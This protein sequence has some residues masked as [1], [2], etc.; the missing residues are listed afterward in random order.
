MDHSAPRKSAMKSGGAA[1]GAGSRAAGSVLGGQSSVGSDSTY[2]RALNATRLAEVERAIFLSVYSM[3]SSNSL[4]DKIQALAFLIEPIQLLATNFAITA[5]TRPAL[6]FAGDSQAV[7]R[8]IGDAAVVLSNPFTGGSDWSTSLIDFWMCFALTCFT[9]VTFVYV[10]YRLTF[11][12]TSPE[13]ALLALRM[14]AMVEST[15]LFMPTVE[16]LMRF[17]LVQASSTGSL[18]AEFIAFPAREVELGLT[19]A[20]WLQLVIFIPICVLIATVAVDVQ[21][22]FGMSH[23]RAELRVLLIKLVLVIIVQLTPLEGVVLAA[24]LKLFL[25]LALLFFVV[26]LQ[27]Y[28]VMQANMFRTAGI[29]LFTW[30]SII[31]CAAALG[32]PSQYTADFFL[33]GAVPALSVGA[34][35]SKMRWQ[36]VVDKM[37]TTARLWEMVDAEE[38]FEATLSSCLTLDDPTDLDI[39]VRQVLKP[40]GATSGY[41]REKHERTLRRVLG[42]RG[43]FDQGGP[44]D[45]TDSG[46]RGGIGAGVDGIRRDEDIAEVNGRLVR[47]GDEERFFLVHWLYQRAVAE[48]GD[49]SRLWTSYFNF[50]HW[51][52]T[53]SRLR[54]TAASL[55]RINSLD[56]RF[57]VFRYLFEKRRSQVGQGQSTVRYLDLSKS[58]RAATVYHGKAYREIKAFWLSIMSR[59]GRPPMDKVRASLHRI[60][61]AERLASAA[62]SALITKHSYS[63]QVLRSYATFLRQVHN[64]PEEADRYIAMADMVEEEAAAEKAAALAHALGKQARRQAARRRRTPPGQRRRGRSDD[65]ADADDDDGYGRHG[66]DD[67]RWEDDAAESVE[68]AE[69]QDADAGA[70][71]RRPTLGLSTQPVPSGAGTPAVDPDADDEG[72]MGGRLDL[73]QP[74][75]GLAVLGGF[76]GGAG[77]NAGADADADAAGV[78]FGDPEAARSGLLE[79]VSSARDGAGDSGSG[80]GTASQSMDGIDELVGVDSVSS[81]SAAKPAGALDGT[82]TGEAMRSTGNPWAESAEASGLPARPAAA[83]EPR[84]VSLDL[85]HGV[86][87]EPGVREQ[88]AAEAMMAEHAIAALREEA[89][90]AEG[91]AGGGAGDDDDDEMVDPTDSAA[92]ARA[93]RAKAS[94]AIRVI[95]TVE[96]ESELANPRT[97]PGI[98]RFRNMLLSCVF[99]A[100]LMLT[101]PVATNMALLSDMRKST[102]VSSTANRREAMMWTMGSLLA[103]MEGGFYWDRAA[104]LSAPDSNA[105]ADVGLKEMTGELLHINHR[106]IFCDY[107][108]AE[109]SSYAHFVDHPV[110]E[111]PPGVA[112]SRS[113]TFGVQGKLYDV[114]SGSASLSDLRAGEE[115][116]VSITIVEIDKLA[117]DIAQQHAYNLQSAAE[118]DLELS[119][120][121][122]VALT[123]AATMAR[124]ARI[125][126]M[127]DPLRRNA[128]LK[129]EGEYQVA[130]TNELEY[131]LAFLYNVK[132][133]VAAMAAAADTLSDR[134]GV[135]GVQFFVVLLLIT[136]LAV[137]NFLIMP[138][139][140]LHGLADGYF[141]QHLGWFVLEAM[142]RSVLREALKLAEG[143]GADGITDASAIAVNSTFPKSGVSVGGRSGTSPAGGGFGAG[144]GD[145]KKAAL[146]GL[147]D[148]TMLPDPVVTRFGSY[149]YQ[150]RRHSAIGKALAK[151]ERS[152]CSG[153]VQVKGRRVPSLAEMGRRMRES[154]KAVA[155]ARMLARQESD[156]QSDDAAY[157]AGILPPSARQGMSIKAPVA[158]SSSVQ[159]NAG[160]GRSVAWFG[161]K[162]VPGSP[163]MVASSGES[164]PGRDGKAVVLPDSA[165]AAAARLRPGAASSRSGGGGGPSADGSTPG[166]SPAGSQHDL[167]ELTQADAEMAASSKAWNPPAVE[168][169]GHAK[170]APG[171]SAS[172]VQTPS[173]PASDGKTGLLAGTLRMPPLAVSTTNRGFGNANLGLGN[174]T[175]M[176]R[177]ASDAS[178]TTDDTRDANRR[179]AWGGST[180]GPDTA[181]EGAGLGGSGLADQAGCCRRRK[182]AKDPLQLL[183]DELKKAV[184]KEPAFLKAREGLLKSAGVVVVLVIALM[185]VLIVTYSRVE[186]L[187]RQFYAMGRYQALFARTGWEQSVRRAR[188]NSQFTWAKMINL[189]EN[190]TVFDEW[191]ISPLSSSGDG[192]VTSSTT[193]ITEVAAELEVYYRC[194]VYGCA[195]LPDP[196]GKPGDVI[197]ID[198]VATS[199]EISIWFFGERA[200]DRKFKEYQSA[201]R[202]DPD[203]LVPTYEASSYEAA[204]ELPRLYEKAF[205][206]W[207]SLYL[208]EVIAVVSVMVVVVLLIMM[209]YIRVFIYNTTIEV[210]EWRFVLSLLPPEELAKVPLA[211]SFITSSEWTTF[212]NHVDSE[213]LGIIDEDEAHI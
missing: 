57:A 177:L 112:V 138:W 19:I 188:S 209:R 150:V 208:I 22:L 25:S 205:E 53:A 146:A 147:T 157:A 195:D 121:L 108:E 6:D 149:G 23:G 16:V 40:P 104:Y 64:K 193:V 114:V 46:G 29:A 3:L 85:G 51:A 74:S 86:V 110:L 33:L 153:S 136:V 125:Y 172:P 9:L 171:E 73:T 78:G 166:H 60:G 134:T 128:A 124:Y 194:V 90:D 66:G 184:V 196:G 169:A 87:V 152:I 24:F 79:G 119:P 18:G 82:V 185:T 8:F 68:P 47:I 123:P 77:A 94:K 116:E 122:Y 32:A 143:E 130:L 20:S 170:V 160:P 106:L 154:R 10:G 70:I 7:S 199:P 63:T 163:V 83:Q 155:S 211:Q 144:G 148:P 206:D 37:P 48:Q 95:G 164:S 182:V 5:M 11:S 202:N 101:V 156:G 127:S 84:R 201:L 187:N 100:L 158:A 92:V 93:R 80:A 180:I 42:M 71:V 56:L 67:R 17:A 129:A 105:S 97:W 36:R 59:G 145:I 109:L 118:T 173:K 102:L 142:P 72:G 52:D 204:R 212:A 98:R 15:V 30:T 179:N 55:A 65:D 35:L 120:A 213:N 12:S 192:T 115:E 117:D 13:T 190:R 168:G 96:V 198:G 38:R 176:R 75:G 181:R 141:E 174:S 76:S 2:S 44:G 99:A 151:L 111:C 189:M 27:P 203:K 210:R 31:E 133:A 126:N 89:A 43:P 161:S 39:A 132:S 162:P 103:D 139:V 62:F 61:E 34:M 26:Q 41:L 69:E 191:Y 1:N 21:G 137:T 178:G 200:I 175:L 186:M 45:A 167:T 58:M 4:K 49:S 207:A 107:P 183:L 91:G 54:M 165:Q 131:T 140:L 81:L 88:A 159:G 113:P 197:A 50:V 28:N 135:V 14:V